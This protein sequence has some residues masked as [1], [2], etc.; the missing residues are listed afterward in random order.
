MIC[1]F[2]QVVVVQDSGEE[3][4]PGGIIIP[5]KSKNKPMRGKVYLAGPECKCVEAGDQVMF[6]KLGIFTDKIGDDEYVFM[7]EEAVLL[8][9]NR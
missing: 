4:T 1:P 5:D 8:V 7:K 6:N 2:N 3:V 9:L